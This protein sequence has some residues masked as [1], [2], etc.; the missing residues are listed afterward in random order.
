MLPLF[1]FVPELLALLRP[2]AAG[3]WQIKRGGWICCL[4]CTCMWVIWAILSRLNRMGPWGSCPLQFDTFGQRQRR[5]KD[6]DASRCHLGKFQLFV[7]VL[8]PADVWVSGAVSGG[9]AWLLGAPTQSR[10]GQCQPAPRRLKCMYILTLP[11]CCLC[12]AEH[13]YFVV[14]CCVVQARQHTLKLN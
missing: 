2:S 7:A 10:L 1:W 9:A 8:A 13:Q 3:C 5:R 6:W 12:Y 4:P 11:L 14:S